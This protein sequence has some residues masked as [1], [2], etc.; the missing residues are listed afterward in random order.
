MLQPNFSSEN[1]SLPGLIEVPG[2]T[3]EIG[4]CTLRKTV[5][6]SFVWKGLCVYLNFFYS[7]QQVSV[8]CLFI[9]DTHIRQP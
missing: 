3:G 1:G 7:L 4:T 2:V 8:A 5:H 9:R 6:L